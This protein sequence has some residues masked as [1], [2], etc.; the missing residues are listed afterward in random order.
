MVSGKASSLYPGAPL[1]L[2]VPGDPGVPKTLAPT[3][4][5][6]FAPRLGL[7]WSPAAQTGFLAKLTG[8]PGKM[9]I[10]AGFGIYYS[11]VEDLSQFLGVG[12]A[13]FGIFWFGGSPLLDAPFVDRKAGG[14]QGQ[15]FP[16]SPPPGNVSASN[17]DT[18]FNWA[19]VGQISSNFYYNPHNRM[20]YSEH[21]HLSIQRQFGTTTVLSVG[22][23]G[24]QGHKNVTSVEANPGNPALCVFLSKQSNLDQ[25]IGLNPQQTAC[26]PGGEDTSS[27]YVLPPGA[28]FPAGATSIVEMTTPCLSNGALTCNAIN[29]TRTIFGSVPTGTGGASFG[30]NPYVSTIAN[31]AYN[32]MQATLKHN[33]SH[34]EFLLGYTYSKCMDNGSSL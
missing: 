21:Y 8:G 3:Q 26:G 20:P 4:Y 13:P 17:P 14:L 22:Y 10:R 19:G 24:N 1:G 30:T 11:S 18:T 12:D 7:A 33:S 32:S 5:D 23:V 34:G 29:S 9:S 25:P 2:V 15:P 31:S 6:A 27:P 28:G 16:F